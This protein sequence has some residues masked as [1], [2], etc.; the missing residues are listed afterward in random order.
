M[1]EEQHPGAPEP[2]LFEPLKT[3]Y[4]AGKPWKVLG[5]GRHFAGCVWFLGD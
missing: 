4:D 5:L 3:G 1:G 2:T